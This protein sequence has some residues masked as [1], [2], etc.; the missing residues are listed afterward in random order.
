MTIVNFRH[1]TI[2]NIDKVRFENIV[3]LYSYNSN[4]HNWCNS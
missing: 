1:A 3:L 4:N 2:Y